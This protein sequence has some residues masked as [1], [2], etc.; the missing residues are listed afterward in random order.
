M[1]CGFSDC[2]LSCIITA[3]GIVLLFVSI[4]ALAY[5]FLLK[6]VKR[7]HIRDIVRKRER[8]LSKIV[9]VDDF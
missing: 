2:I 9:F 3:A 1:A 5:W 4:D 6:E 8:E 7:Y